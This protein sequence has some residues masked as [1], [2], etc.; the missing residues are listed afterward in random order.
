VNEAYKEVMKGQDDPPWWW[1][2]WE[3]TPNH[4]IPSSFGLDLASDPDRFML[5]RWQPM[6]IP[7]L[8]VYTNPYLGTPSFP[9]MP[10][11]KK[12]PYYQR[13]IKRWR[14]AHRGFTIGNGK[15]FV[16]DQREVWCHPD[17]LPKL[18]QALNTVRPADTKETK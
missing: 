11:F 3:R 8:P 1:V 15:Y 16:V 9:A 10:P 4:W 18:K 7:G 17:D 12:G 2:P 14:R 13:R 6:L 5:N